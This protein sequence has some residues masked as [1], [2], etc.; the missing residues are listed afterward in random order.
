MAQY[1][2]CGQMRV[3][4]CMILNE[5]IWPA[6]PLMVIKDQKRKEAFGPI[7]KIWFLHGWRLRHQAKTMTSP[8]IIPSVLGIGRF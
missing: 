8:L 6:E 7:L 1:F 3:S 4:G 2:N 5:F